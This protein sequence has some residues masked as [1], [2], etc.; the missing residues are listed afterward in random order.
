MAGDSGAGPYSSD[1]K[2]SPT[3]T[4]EL[5]DKKSLGTY[6]GFAF[7]GGTDAVAIL[8]VIKKRLKGWRSPDQSKIPY[9]I[10]PVHGT[11][12]ERQSNMFMSSYF[13]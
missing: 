10:R 8:N 13:T 12:Q 5:N 3:L 9:V 2:I 11:L 4:L 6:V 7:F 1:S